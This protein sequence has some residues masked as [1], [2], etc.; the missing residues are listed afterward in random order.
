MEEYMAQIIIYIFFIYGLISMLIDIGN[1]FI[2]AV[3]E[4]NPFIKIVVMV[5]N[6]ENTIEGKIRGLLRSC[7]K[8]LLKE[9]IVLDMGSKDNTMT[10]LKKL[11]TKYECLKI[12]EEEKKDSIFEGF[13]SV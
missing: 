3:A 11:E 8:N 13:D 10:I 2:P 5:K 6:Q 1:L 9:I 7:S 12:L 4:D